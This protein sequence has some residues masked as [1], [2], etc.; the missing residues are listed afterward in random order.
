MTWSVLGARCVKYLINSK[1]KGHLFRNAIDTLVYERYHKC[2]TEGI[3]KCKI[4]KKHMFTWTHVHLNFRTN[5]SFNLKST[6]HPLKQTWVC[7]CWNICTGFH[8]YAIVM[9]V[10]LLIIVF[11]C[12]GGVHS[13]MPTFFHFPFRRQCSLS[14]TWPSG[15]V[16]LGYKA[17][18]YRW[19]YVCLIPAMLDREAAEPCLVRQWGLSGRPNVLLFVDKKL[20]KL[21]F[22]MKQ[23]NVDYS[24]VGERMKSVV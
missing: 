9:F 13:F 21:S 6:Y 18:R 15:D 17:M 16:T 7:R 3:W 24:E 2:A 1:N 8:C 10:V 12:I 23:P 4:R 14:R 19:C 22:G 20:C 11:S 5:P